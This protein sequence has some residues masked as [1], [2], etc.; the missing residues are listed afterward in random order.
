MPYLNGKILDMTRPSK[1]PTSIPATFLV[2][3]NVKLLK[4]SESELLLLWHNKRISKANYSKLNNKEFNKSL[5]TFICIAS[6]V[7]E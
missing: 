5:H 7:L 1:P 4:I 6:S 3:V 2:F